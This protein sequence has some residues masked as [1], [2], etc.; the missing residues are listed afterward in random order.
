MSF[1]CALI[2]RM[3]HDLD[4]LCRIEP[5]IIRQKDIGII[6]KF[7]FVMNNE[8]FPIPIAIVNER[9]QN[10]VI[11]DSALKEKNSGLMRTYRYSR[12]SVSLGSGIGR[13]D[14]TY[15]LMKITCK[16]NVSDFKTQRQ[17]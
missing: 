2:E 13:F 3:T 6:F 16:Q 11:R 4:T 5:P 14:C 9:G 10:G 12:V 7:L 8:H 17:L 15:K 1:V